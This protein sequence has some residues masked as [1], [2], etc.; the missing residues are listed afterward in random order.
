MRFVIEKRKNHNLCVI[1]RKKFGKIGFWTKLYLS[2]PK[3]MSRNGFR[4]TDC[5]TWGSWTWRCRQCSLERLFPLPNPDRRRIHESELQSRTSSTTTTTERKPRG[6]SRRRK[7]LKCKKNCFNQSSTSS[8]SMAISL[9]DGSVIVVLYIMLIMVLKN[10][11]MI[12][13]KNW[14]WIHSCSITFWPFLLF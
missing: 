11:K 1:T 5:P 12:I 13:E 10:S 9:L 3:L 2:D 4:W 14:S 7:C 8:S 6:H